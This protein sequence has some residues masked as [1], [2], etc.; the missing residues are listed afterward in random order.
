MG[1]RLVGGFSCGVELSPMD[2]YLKYWRKFSNDRVLWGLRVFNVNELSVESAVKGRINI[3]WTGRDIY[4]DIRPPFLLY[5]N[6][7]LDIQVRF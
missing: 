1:S 3:A 6:V 7:A 2:K 5:S 4:L